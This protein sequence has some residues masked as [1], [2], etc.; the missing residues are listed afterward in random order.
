MLFRS[1]LGLP[2]N[3][4]RMQS[5]CMSTWPILF[6]FSSLLPS[7]LYIQVTAHFLFAPSFISIPY[8]STSAC[9]SMASSPPP[10]PSYPPPYTSTCPPIILHIHDL[11]LLHHSYPHLSHPPLMGCPVNPSF[12]QSPHPPPS[13]LFTPAQ[14]M[15][16]LLISYPCARELCIHGHHSY[17][18]VSILHIHQTHAISTTFS[19]THHLTHQTR[20]SHFLRHLFHHSFPASSFPF[21]SMCMQPTYMTT[22]AHA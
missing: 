16:P 2:M 19:S 4:M 7:S 22:S 10:Q 1:N 12:P 17:P 15:P 3:S 8:A 11:P 5:S 9:H 13:T 20:F 14:P 6:Q 18:P 21:F